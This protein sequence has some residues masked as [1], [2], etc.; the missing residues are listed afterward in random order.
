M[1]DRSSQAAQTSKPFIISRTVNAPRALVWKAYTE[2]ERL[3][4]W[5]GPKGFIT[6]HATLDLRP[7]GIYHYCMRASDGYEMWGKWIFR[8]IVEPER[9]VVLVSF[10]DVHGGIARNPM[11]PTW[12]L[13]SLSTTT[14]VEQGDKT[15]IT[16]EWSA[17]DATEEE[18]KTFDAGHESMRMGFTGTFDQLDA[19]LAS[20]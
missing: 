15:L 17:Y 9:L 13:Q 1:N 7:G 4:Q 8:E 5:F 20:L 16:I 19:Y 10:S 6:P 14:L 3:M 12:P 18:Q 2:R 11:S